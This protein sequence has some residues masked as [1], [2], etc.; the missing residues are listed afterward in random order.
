MKTQEIINQLI[1]LYGKKSAV[2]VAFTAELDKHWTGREFGNGYNRM[3]LNIL[4]D[5]GLKF[6]DDFKLNSNTANS[7]HSKL[8]L[9]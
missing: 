9:K 5:L 4:S 7:V 3:I 1:Q 2:K 6:S 8:S